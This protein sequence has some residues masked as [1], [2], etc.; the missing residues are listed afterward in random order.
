[1]KI[2]KMAIKNKL[3]YAIDIPSS[4]AG[5]LAVALAAVSFKVAFSAAS[6][7]TLSAMMSFRGMTGSCHQPTTS[8]VIFALGAR[9]IW[10]CEASYS[11]F[12]AVSKDSRLG[13]TTMHES[14]GVLSLSLSLLHQANQ[15]L[16]FGDEKQCR[17]TR[18]SWLVRVGWGSVSKIGRIICFSLSHFGPK[19]AHFHFF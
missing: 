8:H 19:K 6:T 4:V 17:E 15:N 11:W 13:R 16:C 9:A 7:V 14:E 5:T 12:E 3:K 10:Q 18:D 2:G 1:M